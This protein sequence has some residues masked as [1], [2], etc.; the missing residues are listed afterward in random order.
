VKLDFIK[1]KA[2]TELSHQM[3]FAKV[4]SRLKTLSTTV[5]DTVN[6]VTGMREHLDSFSSLVAEI[7]AKHSVMHNKLE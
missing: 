7:K 3:D 1:L 6:R 5:D 2:Q 4:T